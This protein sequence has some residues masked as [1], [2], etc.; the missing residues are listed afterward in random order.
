MHEFDLCERLLDQV[1]DEHAKRRFATV[2]RVRVEIGQLS[3]ADPEAMLHAFEILARGTFLEGADF[4]IERVPSQGDCLDCGASVVVTEP[5]AV[6][7]S[8]QG[9]RLL[10]AP[11]SGTRFVEIEVI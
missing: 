11:G 7:P 3:S 9:T 1:A 10:A 6:C 4:A 2:K 8:C 5:P